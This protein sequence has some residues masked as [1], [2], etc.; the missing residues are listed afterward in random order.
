MGNSGD[1]LDYFYEEIMAMKSCVC[2][3]IVKLYDIKKTENHFYVFLEYCSD[4]DLQKY[5]RKKG[6]LPE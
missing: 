4:G 5:I 3:N 6:R 1:A 2:D